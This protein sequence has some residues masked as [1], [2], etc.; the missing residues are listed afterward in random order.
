[1]ALRVFASRGFERLAP[2]Q[3]R[4]IGEIVIHPGVPDTIHVTSMDPNNVAPWAQ[5]SCG[6]VTYHEED[7]DESER[8]EAVLLSGNDGFVHQASLCQSHHGHPPT[9]GGFALFG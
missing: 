3:L 7:C 8:S 1:M 5:R 2:T 6:L 4:T 9:I